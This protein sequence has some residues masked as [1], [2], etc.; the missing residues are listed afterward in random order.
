MCVKTI[1]KNIN[2]VNKYVNVLQFEYR[3]PN[4]VYHK[5]V[6]ILLLQI[7]LLTAHTYV[8]IVFI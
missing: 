1:P 3:E 2:E 5:C 6:F 8:F 4:V 7:Y